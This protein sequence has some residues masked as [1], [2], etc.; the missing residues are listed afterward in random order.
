[1]TETSNLPAD[2][3]STLQ[4][5]LHEVQ[6]VLA[7][8]RRVENL[9]HRQDMPRH[10]LVENLVHKQHLNELQH[11]LGTMSSARIARILEALPQDDGLL[12]WEMIGPERGEEVLN[13]LSDSVKHLPASSLTSVAPSC[14]TPS[15]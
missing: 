12:L 15:N 4:L 9:V 2:D 14:S 1:M 11:R 7:R 8:Q 6:E 5:D 10:E 3:E 13:E